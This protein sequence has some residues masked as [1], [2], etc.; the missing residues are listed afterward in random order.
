NGKDENVISE[1]INS[2]VQ[3][4]FVMSRLG[5]NP[6]SRTK[7]KTLWCL[8]LCVSPAGGMGCGYATLVYELIPQFAFLVKQFFIHLNGRVHW[9]CIHTTGLKW[10]GQWA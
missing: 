1:L 2:R 6:A 4:S 7:K 10:P 5:G 8:C 3:S 9:R